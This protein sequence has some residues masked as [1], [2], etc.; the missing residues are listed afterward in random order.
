VAPN[1]K[2]ST[3]APSVSW[4]KRTSAFVSR[5][6]CT[7]LAAAAAAII[8]ADRPDTRL[9]LTNGLASFF[10]GSF[11]FGGSL[12]FLA[13]NVKKLGWGGSVLLDCILASINLGYV[14]I[15]SR[16]EFRVHDWRSMIVQYAIAILGLA[17]GIYYFKHAQR[18]VER[19]IPFLVFGLFASAYKVFNRL[20]YALFKTKL[21]GKVQWSYRILSVLAG[22]GLG[23]TNLEAPM[24]DVMFR[25]TTALISVF[26]VVLL[27]IKATALLIVEG[28]SQKDLLDLRLI[29]K[30]ALAAFA[31]TKVG[32]VFSDEMAHVEHGSG[33][34]EALK[35]CVV[36]A[37][38]FY[39]ASL[40]VV[41]LRSGGH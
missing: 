3:K 14:A 19:V 35:T 23:S 37:S 9:L 36:L 2:L 40:A 12:V 21:S 27:V 13:C 20:M 41:S 15:L 11:G 17:L 24:S 7:I 29:A 38:L 18:D 10:E 31:F 25:G 4:L 33:I 6:S 39:L 1:E 8:L 32:S 30:L 5:Y 22:F 26:I 16:K 34:K 28:G